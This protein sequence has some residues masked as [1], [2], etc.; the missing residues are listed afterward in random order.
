MSVWDITADDGLETAAKQLL[1]AVK[2]KLEGTRTGNTER[3]TEIG[4]ELQRALTSIESSWSGHHL[5]KCLAERELAGLDEMEASA[6][7]EADEAEE[8]AHGAG[9]AL[10]DHRTV[11]HAELGDMLDQL[12]SDQADEKRNI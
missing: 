6:Q 8:A 3:A 5:D 11:V 12:D 9:R 10:S 4:R 2:A 7:R 1:D